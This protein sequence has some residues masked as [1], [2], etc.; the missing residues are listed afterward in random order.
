VLYEDTKEQRHVKTYEVS[1]RDKVRHD[2][3]MTAAHAAEHRC[4]CSCSTNARAQG[5]QRSSFS[6][7]SI[8]GL[9]LEQS[10]LHAAQYNRRRAP[11]RLCALPLVG[12]EL[13]Q[14]GTCCC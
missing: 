1:L 9:R 11:F 8:V 7:A 13:S 6:C 4:K 12:V 5:G 2:S 10:K 14:P 3:G